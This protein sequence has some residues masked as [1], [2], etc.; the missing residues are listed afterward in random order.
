MLLARAPEELQAWKAAIE[1]FLDEHLALRLNPRRERMRLLSD[2]VDFL[3]YIVRPFH[4]LVRRRVVGHLR[5]R[6]ARSRRRLVREHPDAIEYRFD[7]AAL[8]ALQAS[9]SSY[10]GH[11]GRASSQ[12]VG[13]VAVGAQPLARQLP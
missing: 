12:S 2:G 7:P 10:L 13:G 5:E 8:D 9:L 4:L 6:L 3:G 11:L 1:A